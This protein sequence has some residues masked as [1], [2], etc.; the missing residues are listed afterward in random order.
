VTTTEKFLTT[1]REANLIVLARKSIEAE[2]GNSFKLLGS[3]IQSALMAEAVLN[4]A[5]LQD[6]DEVSDESVRRI[7]NTGQAWAAGWKS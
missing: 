7:V 5:S 2:W 6:A 1:E 4:L 3:R